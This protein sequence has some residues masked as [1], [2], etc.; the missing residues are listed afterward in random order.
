M[1]LENPTTR[2]RATLALIRQ[3][4]RNYKDFQKVVG[5]VEQSLASSPSYRGLSSGPLLLKPYT[6]HEFRYIKSADGVST[7]N[8][9]VIFYSRDMAYVLSLSCPEQLREQNEA[10]FDALVQGLVI[11]KVRKDITPKGAPQT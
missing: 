10:D 3:R 6:A 9:M 7:F 11:K 4:M 2:A 8:R 1:R 5:G